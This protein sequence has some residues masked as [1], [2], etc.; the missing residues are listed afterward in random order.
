MRFSPLSI[1]VCLMLSASANLATAQGAAPATTA[2]PVQGQASVRESALTLWS[3][4]PATAWT[5]ALAIGNGR[6]GAMLFGAPEHDR[7][8]INDITVWSGGPMLKADRPNAYKALPAIREALAKGDYA[9]GTQLVKENMTTTGTGDSEYWPSYETL[10]D[11]TFDHKLS[12]GPVT[13]YLRTLDIENAVSGV[14]FTVDG[15]TYTRESFASAP[16][17]AI[18]SHFTSDKPGSI[19]FTLKLSRVAS[20]TTSA[21]GNDTLVMRGDSTF[22]PQPARPARPPI[23]TGPRAGFPGFPAKPPQ[24]ARP[25]NLDYEA[26]I[27]VKT[28]GGS[29]RAEGDHLV[30]EGANEATVVL[31]AGTSYVLDFDKGFKGGNP[32]DAVTQQLESASAKTYPELRSA[33]VKD[34]RGYFDRVSFALPPTPAAHEQT[35]VRIEKYGDGKADP[36][37]AVLYYQMGRYLLISSSRPE[38]PLPSNS[39]G[40]W[41]DGLDLPWKC[42]YKSNINYQMNYWPSE[43]ANLGELHMPAIRFDAAL[44]KPGTKTAQTYYNAPGWVV[45][46]TANAW[47][48]TSPGEGMP[49][50]PFFGGGGWLMQDVWEHYA[51]SRDRD[52]LRTYYPVLKGSAEFYLSILVPDANGKLITSPS[53][54]PENSYRTD[55]GVAGSV[56]DGSAVEREIIWDLFTNTIAASRVLDTDAEFR[57]K[58]EKAKAA[59]RPLEIGKAG[60]LEEWGHDWD[61]NAREMNHRHVSHLFAA[62]PGW[63]ITPDTTP[64]LAAAVRKSLALRGDEATG[65]SNA[66]KINLYARLRDGDH[67]AKILAEQLRL[68]SGVG[69]DYHGEGGGT[70]GNMFDSHPPFQIDGNFGSTS[71]IDEML[72]QSDQRYSETPGGVEDSYLIDLLPALPSMWPDGSMH[73]L[74]ARGGFEVDLDWKAGQLTSAYIRSVGGTTARLRY[75]GKTIPVKLAAGQTLH[76]TAAGGTL[77]T[78]IEAGSPSLVAESNPR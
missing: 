70:Y 45:A 9:A 16:D 37:L 38:N 15:V 46:Y 60:Q 41:G 13:N 72:L 32:H 58:L 2:R 3:R 73:G 40:I 64:A 5:D 23:T 7:F 11:V 8:Q 33:H 55:A 49:Y 47:G 74:R 27:R 34:Y 53:L 51:F 69:T 62:Y 6:L 61:L 77:Q 29:V 48:W 68:S 17:H 44:V 78:S 56:V 24:A 25:G 19:S 36:S 35:D 30:V 54:S 4:T 57:A 43:T 52:F 20:A 63:E 67:A 10:G 66:W 39:Q 21:V 22:P 42:D 1:V 71:G 18:V 31:V 14:R 28:V 65:W 59:M 50:G 12:S 75:A 76:V 26:Q